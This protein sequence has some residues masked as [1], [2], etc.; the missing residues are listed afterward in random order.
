MYVNVQH[1]E[2][3]DFVKVEMKEREATRLFHDLNRLMSL[4][5][6]ARDTL[7]EIDGEDGESYRRVH[8]FLEQLQPVVG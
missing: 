6:A 7:G 1:S 3:G 2:C 5:D 4:I 8:A